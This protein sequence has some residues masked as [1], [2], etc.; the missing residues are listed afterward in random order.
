MSDIILDINSV[1]K[2]KQLLYPRYYYECDEKVINKVNRQNYVYKFEIDLKRVLG[3]SS[4]EIG[5][6]MRFAKNSSR[7]GY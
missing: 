6:Q 5:E 2:W 4:A 1:S 7:K 3:Y